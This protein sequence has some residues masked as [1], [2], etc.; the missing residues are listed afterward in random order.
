MALLVPAQP[1]LASQ[2]SH[3]KSFVFFLNTTHRQVNL[4][5]MDFYGFQDFFTTLK[6]G[7]GIKANTFV[8]HP[9]I[10]RDAQTGERMHVK[11]QDIFW[12]QLYRVKNAG[13]LLPCRKL[14]AIHLPVTP[15]LRSRCLWVIAQHIYGDNA[16]G[17]LENM[18]LPRT[19]HNDLNSILELIEKHKSMGMQRSVQVF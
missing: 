4:Y 16:N 13:Q 7:A 10:F 8:T 1:R 18:A 12:P 5:W 3:E 19:L 15:T 14:I 11:H 9:W 6:P 2:N 17:V